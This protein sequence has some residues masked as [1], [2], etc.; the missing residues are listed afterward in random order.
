[1]LNIDKTGEIRSRDIKSTKNL[2][3]TNN[4]SK[5]K[6]CNCYIV[7]VPTPVKANNTPDFT[8]LLNASKIVGKI[9]NLKDIQSPPHHS[10]F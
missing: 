6:T 9:L 3:F 1:M 8:Q 5:I 10:F 2:K 4:I 7:A